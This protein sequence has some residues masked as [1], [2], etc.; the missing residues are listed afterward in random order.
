MKSDLFQMMFR[1]RFAH[2]AAIFLLVL[3][4]GFYWIFG[5]MTSALKAEKK[6]QRDL[7]SIILKTEVASN[8][9]DLSSLMENR[10]N[11]IQ[12]L[13][14]KTLHPGEQSKVISM[15]T[16]VMEDLSIRLIHL[17]PAKEIEDTS[18]S[19]P[20]VAPVFFILEME[21]SYRILGA[22]FES[23]SEEAPKLTL[24]KILIKPHSSNPDALNIQMSLAAYEE[25]GP[26]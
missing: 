3:L 6:Q 16:R 2:W 23:L 22:F 26:L 4:G 10:Q 9:K 25:A 7:E 12:N 1:I 15:L 18:K 20:K 5:P 17:E 8:I 11:E 13:Q 19:S 21:S 24:E 14:K